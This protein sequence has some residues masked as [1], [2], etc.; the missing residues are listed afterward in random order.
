MYNPSSNCAMKHF[1]QKLKSA[2][3]AS[4][5]SELWFLSDWPSNF[6]KVYL[7]TPCILQVLLKPLVNCTLVGS[8]VPGLIF[9]DQILAVLCRN[10]NLNKKQIMVTEVFYQQESGLVRRWFH[11]E[12][13]LWRTN[14]G[15]MDSTGALQNS[16]YSTQLNS[17]VLWK[18]RVDQ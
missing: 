11:G 12:E 14:M 6:L 7:T 8:C 2:V 3:K 17:G 5:T 4:G 1:I 18:C 16:H 9:F 13:I 15:S 10:D